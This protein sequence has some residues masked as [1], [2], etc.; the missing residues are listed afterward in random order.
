MKILD[1]LNFWFSV[2]AAQA[3]FCTQAF[4][5]FEYFMRGDCSAE[6]QKWCFS[7]IGRNILHRNIWTM[8]HYCQGG[9]LISR[10]LLLKV[11]LACFFLELSQG[12]KIKIS[13]SEMWHFVEAY[14][15]FYKISPWCSVAVWKFFVICF[16]MVLISVQPSK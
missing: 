14:P 3:G 8:S 15:L 1:F 6:E 11:N 5:R 9:F 10:L 4:T 13:K 12:Q 2:Y 7:L 16:D